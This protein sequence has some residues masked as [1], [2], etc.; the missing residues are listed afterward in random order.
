MGIPHGD[1]LVDVSVRLHHQERGYLR[2][3]RNHMGAGRLLRGGLLRKGSLRRLDLGHRGGKV[4]VGGGRVSAKV[5]AAA[6]I[7]W[8][9]HFCFFVLRLPWDPTSRVA[10][11]LCSSCLLIC[12]AFPALR[13]CSITR[14]VI[15]AYSPSSEVRRPSL[16]R[17]AGE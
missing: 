6:P 8:E 9:L 1:L 13:D 11:W 10:S 2:P 17:R 12:V 5:S 14:L 7:L 15:E 4:Q 3:S 16:R